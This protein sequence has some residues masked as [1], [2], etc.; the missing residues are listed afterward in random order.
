MKRVRINNL[1]LASLFVGIGIVLPI[2]FHAAGLGPVFLP[3]HIPV[4]LSGYFLPIPLALAVGI[5]TPIL[6]SLL[7]GMPPI[8]PVPPYMIFES[9]TYAF[10]T[11][12]LYRKMKLNVYVSLIPSMIGGRVVSGLTVWVMLTFFSVKLPIFFVFMYSSFLKGLPGVIV[13]IILIPLLVKFVERS[14]LDE[15]L[16]GIF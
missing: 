1:V 8:L 7:T 10:L 16:T 6:S 3:M 13:Q 2:F 15:K 11:S 12:L 14:Y 9:A 5:F 4:M